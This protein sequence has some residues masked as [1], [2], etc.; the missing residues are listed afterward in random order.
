MAIIP[1]SQGLLD[2]DR[3]CPT[4]DFVGKTTLSYAHAD[5]A[6]IETVVAVLPRVMGKTSVEEPAKPAS[7]PKDDEAMLEYLL[8]SL[9]S[10]QKE[11]LLKRM[12]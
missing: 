8:T 2:I 4:L 3:L 6:E 7:N 12:S 1:I 11:K 10:E 5:T 9:T